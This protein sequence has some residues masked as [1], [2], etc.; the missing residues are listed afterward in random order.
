MLSKYFTQAT[1]SIQ[2]LFST[3]VNVLQSP[4]EMTYF[5]IMPIDILIPIFDKLEL[6]DVINFQNISQ[7]TQ[8]AAAYYYR[9][10]FSTFFLNVN[11]LASVACCSDK[12]HK[13]NLSFAKVM[14]RVVGPYVQQL[15]IDYPSFCPGW[16][17]PLSKMVYKYCG[18]LVFVQ[19]AGI[20]GHRIKMVQTQNV[21]VMSIYDCLFEKQPPMMAPSKLCKLSYISKKDGLITDIIP[22]IREH[23]NIKKLYIFMNYMQTT[24]LRSIASLTCLKTLIVYVSP[25]GTAKELQ[26][27]KSMNFSVVFKDLQVLPKLV[28]VELRLPFYL[29]LSLEIIDKSVKLLELHT[30]CKVYRT[31]IVNNIEPNHIQ[32]L[33]S[34]LNELN[35]VFSCIQ[36]GQYDFLTSLLTCERL[37]LLRLILSN[38]TAKFDDHQIEGVLVSLVEGARN[39]NCCLRILELNAGHTVPIDVRHVPFILELLQRAKQLKVLRLK[40]CTREFIKCKAAFK[41]YNVRLAFD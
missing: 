15:L 34:D 17:R 36:V 32:Y 9:R 40:N 12:N 21:K 4:Q 37:E 13:A 10:R 2:N 38:Q 29:R 31:I 1:K 16:V 26:M 23:P 6:I 18:N 30:K 39:E 27:Q 11:S 19:I 14:F 7:Q 28:Y 41:I 24:H 22:L 25:V 8:G 20:P 3:R 5:D 33:R 35:G